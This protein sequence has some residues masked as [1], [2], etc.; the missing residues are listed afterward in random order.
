MAKGGGTIDASGLFT[1]GLNP[2]SFPDTVTAE[3]GGKSGTASVEVIRPA[4][5]SITV[6]P[7]EATV[8]VGGTMQFAAAAFDSNKKE[9]PAVTFKWTVAAGGGTIDN[10]GL[11]TGGK[12]PGRYTNTVT[13]TAGAITGEA[14]V[15]VLKGELKKL[16]IVPTD[17]SVKVGGMIQFS[18]RGEDGFGNEL[19]V[20][21][22]WTLLNGGGKLSQ[23]GLFT[24]G[25][26][27]GEFKD[28]VQAAMT[29]APFLKVAATVKVTK[30]NPPKIT[31][32]P[33][34]TAT[35][36]A[37]YV[38]KVEAADPE[39]D[40][41]V[42]SLLQAPKGM[43][44][45]AKS[46]RI[47]WTPQFA[48]VG[49]H[50]VTAEASD[51]QGTDQ[52]TWKVT[53]AFTDSDNDNLP[54]TWEMKYFGALGKV[55]DPKGDYDGDG[56]TNRQEYDNDTDP[57]KSNA[58]GAPSI[59]F[60]ADGNEVKSIRPDL[61]V[62]NAADPDGD[63]LKYEWEV[64]SDETLSTL[65]AKSKKVDETKST[66]LWTVDQDLIENNW[67]WWRAR[68]FDPYGPSKWTRTVK[69]MVNVKNDPPSKPTP[70]TPADQSEVS[71]L[72]P[73]LTVNNARDPEG[74]KLVYT[75]EVAEDKEFKKIV[76]KS[77]KVP[78][79]KFGST[80][81]E[82]ATPLLENSNYFWRAF[83]SDEDGADGPVSDAFSF[84]VNTAND[85]PDKPVIVA[86]KDREEVKVDT[87]DL[88]VANAVDPDGDEVQ[89]EIEVDNVNTFDSRYLQKSGLIKQDPSGQ[90]KW[91]PKALDENTMWYWRVRST[92]GKAFS[93]WVVSSFFVNT[94]N[95]EP[96][97]VTIKNPSDG[98][99]GQPAD[100]EIVTTKAVDPDIYD[101]LTYTY[102][103]FNDRKLTDKAQEKKGVPEP[104]DAKEIRWQVDPAL[105]LGGRFW[106]RVR[107]VDD[108]GLEGAWSDP[109]MFRVK[110]GDNNAPSQVEALLPKKDEKVTLKKPLLVVKHA[111]DK[112]GDPM[113][114]QFELFTDKELKKKA[115][116]NEKT[117]VPG[118]GTISCKAS[119]DEQCVLVDDKPS[120]VKVYDKPAEC[121]PTACKDDEACVAG[122]CYKRIAQV[123]W[124]VGVVL[125]NKEYYWHARACDNF[126][127]CGP[128][129]E[130]RKFVVDVPVPD[131]GPPED[132]IKGGG[133]DCNADGNGPLT[134]GMALLALLFL[135]GGA[136]R[137][138]R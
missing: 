60:P 49:E 44:I 55:N 133:C 135:L 125:T 116:S 15:T 34:T 12:T 21:V 85:T 43:G 40:P 59:N 123:S 131:A 39:G 68:A 83:A 70:T 96:G 115:A 7:N 79:G 128:W 78:E 118:C 124:Q 91:Q 25:I 29:E 82:V 87:P 81:W 89:L 28:T 65:V 30:T 4:I 16:V 67:Y 134:G 14:S 73:T 120:C 95:D 24:A 61:S 52:Q 13:A 62:T 102:Q 54:D 50:S 1:A 45:D 48:E 97:K 47:T 111:T 71:K 101:K 57:T 137:R 105:A 35:E 8:K 98:A 99:T 27:V 138:R 107:A 129:S 38:Y 90:T 74:K 136:L 88:V 18:A 64:Y 109:V 108:K 114:Y 9:I 127:L 37:L 126:K 93:D 113:T 92:D 100:L 23:D 36:G 63:K 122:R 22:T 112:D 84:T 26:N 117:P 11:F 77:A 69:F 66:T 132:E 6:L 41:I 2:G 20:K 51:G 76:L 86:P 58:P 106:V 42:Y 130:T 80:S 31:S 119:E 75:F 46:G 104:K 32:T 5:A 17:P 19:P 72:Q 94:T 110:R 121:K 10:N 103:F 53:V 3:A 33:V 56:M